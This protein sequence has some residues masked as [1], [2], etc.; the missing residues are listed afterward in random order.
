VIARTP[1]RSGRR[2][3]AGAPRLA[4]GADWGRVPDD[5]RNSFMRQH[6]CALLL[7]LAS[8]WL[9]TALPT[10]AEA[11]MQPQEVFGLLERAKNGDASAVD[12]LRQQA[13][14]GDPVAQTGLATVYLAGL[15]GV[16]ADDVEAA[17]WT[18]AA[19]DQGFPPAEYDMALL[20]FT[21][22]GVARDTSEAAR[23]LQKASDKGVA[24]AQNNLG[25]L[26]AVGEGVPKEP[27]KAAALFRKAA[28]Q[29]FAEA[30]NNLGVLYANG[31]GVK[32][33]NKQALALFQKAAAQG[34]PG[35]QRNI[36]RLQ[37]AQNQTPPSPKK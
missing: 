21:G 32:K 8:W 23:W 22:R 25:L 16:A 19:A 12:T 11:M 1:G 5:R 31:E 18:R 20:Y 34:H 10:T 9:A 3:P 35:A 27:A 36:E 7:A 17:R 26:Y 4:K 33:D 6:L 37:Q 30:Q 24:P 14:A 15:G 28:D 2:D 13:D 29:G